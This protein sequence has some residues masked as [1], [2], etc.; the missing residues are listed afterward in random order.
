MSIE[1]CSKNSLVSYIKKIPQSKSSTF[2]NQ[3]NLALH[4]HQSLNYLK[5]RA[6]DPLFTKMLFMLNLVSFSKKRYQLNPCS[7]E[8]PL[9][10]ISVFLRPVSPSPL[11]RQFCSQCSV[12]VITETLFLKRKLA[13]NS[14]PTVIHKDD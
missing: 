2:T 7:F 14:F 9:L 6:G 4:L 12:D 13:Y 1:Y 11:L 3:K 5:P 10:Q 8:L